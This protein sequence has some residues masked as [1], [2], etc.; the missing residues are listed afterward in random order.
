MLDLKFSLDVQPSDTD[1]YHAVHRFIEEMGARY[2][3]EVDRDTSPILFKADDEPSGMLF[4]LTLPKGEPHPYW[5]I[6]E[7][8]MSHAEQIALVMFRGSF[9][10]IGAEPFG[11]GRLMV[12]ERFRIRGYVFNARRRDEWSLS[13][14]R[15]S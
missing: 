9:S 6:R 15:V 8:E 4:E 12:D 1:R 7:R 13:V 2:A 5:R 3:A 10:R 14:D 11:V